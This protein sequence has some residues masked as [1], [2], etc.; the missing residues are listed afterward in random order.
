[1]SISWKWLNHISHILYTF[2]L[3]LKYETMHNILNESI[4]NNLPC[5][6]E[7]VVTCDIGLSALIFSISQLMRLYNYL[8]TSIQ[9]IVILLPIFVIYEYLCSSIIQHLSS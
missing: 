6:W 2:N 1:M 3:I 7:N 9:E 4:N 5:S 8:A